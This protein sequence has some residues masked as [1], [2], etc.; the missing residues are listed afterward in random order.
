[1]SFE[2]SIQN[3]VALDNQIK[4][5]SDRLKE[6]RTKR[7]DIGDNIISYVE[8]NELSNAVVKISDGNTIW[9]D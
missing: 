7:N 8:T 2:S 5:L 1:M 3:W 9:N 6:L 4:T